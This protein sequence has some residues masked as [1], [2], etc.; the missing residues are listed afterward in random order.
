[1]S[2]IKFPKSSAVFTPYLHRNRPFLLFY[3]VK[4]MDK[5]DKPDVDK[6]ELIY[7]EFFKYLDNSAGGSK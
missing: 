5:V 6:T 1:M 2:K 7:L 3:K 4:K